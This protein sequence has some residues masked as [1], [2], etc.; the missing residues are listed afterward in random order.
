MWT[1]LSNV[2]DVHKHMVINV[3]GKRDPIEL[4]QSFLSIVKAQIVFN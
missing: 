2:N 4:D 1:W 3:S